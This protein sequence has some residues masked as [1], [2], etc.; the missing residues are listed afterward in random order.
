MNSMKTQTPALLLPLAAVTAGLAPVLW[1]ALQNPHL[2]FDPYLWNVLRFTLL[3]ATLSTLL[4][5]IFGFAFGRALAHARFP[6]HAILVQLLSLP[7]A[8][9][10]IVAVLGIIS[11]FGANGVLGGTFNLYGLTGILVAHVFFNF[12]LAARLAYA[13][14]QSIPDESRRLAAQLNFSR[15]QEWQHLE[16]P[17]LRTILPGTALLV[18]L[19]C[20]ASFT[21]VLT[22]GGGPQA[23]TLEVAIY[24]SLR[25]DFDPARAAMLS[26]LQIALCAILVFASQKFSDSTKTFPQL[27]ITQKTT[28]ST[29]SFFDIAMLLAG[30]TLLLP[31]LAAILIDGLRAFSATQVP[32]APLLSSIAIGAISALISLT[33]IW[34]LAASSSRA[35]A[36]IVLSA[37]ILPPAVIATGW[38]ILLSRFS[39]GNATVAA[40]IIALNTLMALPFAWNVLRPAFT[41]AKADHDKLCT[42]LSITG[43]TRF[44]L[45]DFPALRRPAALAFVM[46]MI[47]SLGDLTAVLLFGSGTITTLPAMIYQQMGSY[48]F[49]DAASSALILATLATLLLII[50]QK[51]S[52]D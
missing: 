7:L 44:R 48:R 18:F 17:T 24:Q 39:T 36:T 50:A 3:Q 14:L 38:F 52:H 16:W 27:R 45:I 43:L 15:R 10:A 4:S 51:L 40:L 13:S 2:T 8:L 41:R 26:L 1:L 35:A 32:V 9:P 37:L 42:S 5:I 49:G 33:I 29:T 6:G 28:T 31:P 20:A 22:L 34:P 46:A 25:F 21:I 30:A 11:I 23:T 47:V 12:P 19:L